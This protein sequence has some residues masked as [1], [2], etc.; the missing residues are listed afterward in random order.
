MA[1]YEFES[2]AGGGK[3][4]AEGQVGDDDF[5]VHPICTDDSDCENCVNPACPAQNGGNWVI[6]TVTLGAIARCT[7]RPMARA[8]SGLLDSSPEAI[9]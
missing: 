6:S 2:W 5:L 9:S 3:A 8:I 7:S 4:V 1:V